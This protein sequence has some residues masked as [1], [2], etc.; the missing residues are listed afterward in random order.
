MTKTRILLVDDHDIVRLGLMTLLNDQP[1]ME[2]IGE[3]STAAEAV[4][5]RARLPCVLPRPQLPGSGSGRH[6]ASSFTVT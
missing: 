4:R 5:L 6:T 3:A 2:V 1:D